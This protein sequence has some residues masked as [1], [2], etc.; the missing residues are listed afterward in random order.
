MEF[1]TKTISHGLFGGA[2]DSFHSKEDEKSANI[3]NLPFVLVRSAQ[4]KQHFFHAYLVN[5]LKLS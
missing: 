1:R 4:T 2:K 5:N 3:F